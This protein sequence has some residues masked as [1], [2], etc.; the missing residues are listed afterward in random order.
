LESGIA[1]ND[2][3]FCVGFRKGSDLTQ[4][5]NGF[6]KTA[7]EDGTISSLANQYGIENAVLE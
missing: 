7:Y 5:V 3:K 1:L 6:L 2:E 4:K